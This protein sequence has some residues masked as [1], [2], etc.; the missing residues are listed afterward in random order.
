MTLKEVNTPAL[1][2]EF[3][4][5]PVRLY[6]NDP[7]YIR[8]LDKDVAEVF[9][10]KTNRTFK[11]KGSEVVRWLLIDSQG[12]TLGRL[13]AFV[14]TR[15]SN[16]YDQPT[17]GIGFFDCI[18]DQAAANLLFDAGKTWL[19]NRGM[20]AMDG[21]INFGERDKFWGLLIDGFEEQ[22]YGMNYNA[23][24]Y[25]T[26]FEN[27]GFQVFFN[28]H[29]YGRPVSTR[30]EMDIDPRMYERGQ[31]TLRNGEVTFR[32]LKKSEFD[33]APEY[34]LH[35]YNNAWGNHKGVKPMTLDQAKKMFKKLTPIADERLI[36]FGFHKNEPIAFYISIPELN[37]LFKYVNGK[38]DLIGK[39]KFVWH[40][41]RGSCKKMLGIV[42]GVVPAWQGK[43][44]ES[45]IVIEFSKLAWG[46]DFPYSRVEMNWIGDFNPKMMRV[47]EQ[48]GARIVR[49]HATY[50]YLFDRQ[51]EFKR[52][53]IIE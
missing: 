29:T 8:P 22:N 24:Y 4:E 3:I 45:A 26:L 32:Y 38:M 53:A 14:N 50:R 21:P 7:H 36:W 46:K 35:V 11:S 37:Q 47:C 39:L 12:K 5:F 49:T 27:Y 52:C 16:T 48:I 13:A 20:E 18:N 19:A 31:M 42:F 44:V 2:R 9:D 23:P 25:K 43:G 10:P 17:G 41:W 28:Q 15:T 34:F 33:K 30:D 1:E 51:K 6:A 40:R